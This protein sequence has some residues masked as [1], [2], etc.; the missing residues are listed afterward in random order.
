MS[1]PEG[2]THSWLSW[3]KTMGFEEFC[4]VNIVSADGL[5][6]PEA[7]TRFQIMMMMICWQVLANERRRYIC[8]GFSHW[9]RPCWNIE[10]ESRLNS[11]GPTS[12]AIW[13]QRSG[14]ALAQVMASCLMVPSHYLT[15]CWLVAGGFSWH[16]LGGISILNTPDISHWNEFK[17]CVFRNYC[18]IFQGPMS[19]LS[20]IVCG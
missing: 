13:H 15:Q 12:D 8:N 5:A 14:S 3:V 9:L 18:H 4:S 7:M 11:L 6:E 10:I 17:Y 16:S 1:A 2:L 19:P 20:P